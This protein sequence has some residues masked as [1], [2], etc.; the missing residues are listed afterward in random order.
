VNCAHAI[1]ETLEDPD[2]AVFS[3]VG[4]ALITA[5]V[6]NDAGGILTYSQAG[7]QFGHSCSGR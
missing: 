4:P 5:N 1:P 6:D 7:A 2:P 3:V